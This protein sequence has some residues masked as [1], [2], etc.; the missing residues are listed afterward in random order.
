VSGLLFRFLIGFPAFYVMLKYLFELP[1]PGIFA[2][3]VQN[4]IHDIIL[5]SYSVPL[6]YLLAEV[7]QKNLKVIQTKD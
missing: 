6:S 4:M 7:I 3:S 1:D 2:A 5:V